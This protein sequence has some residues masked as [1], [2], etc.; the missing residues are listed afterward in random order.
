MHY[1]NFTIK[2]LEA[3][4]HNLKIELNENNESFCFPDAISI[5]DIIALRT[6]LESIWGK[7]DSAIALISNKLYP[8]PWLYFLKK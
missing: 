7:S 3:I 8:M 2:Y 1:N 4:K 5:E 6:E